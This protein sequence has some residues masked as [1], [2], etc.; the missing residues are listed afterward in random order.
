VAFY[1]SP[2]FPERIAR[3]AEGGPEFLTDIAEM[4]SGY[5]SRNIAWNEPRH[6]YVVTLLNRP[7]SEFDELKAFFI[8]VR[9]MGHGFRF[10]DVADFSATSTVGLLGTGVGTGSAT[11]QM[12][13]RYTS[14]SNNFDRAIK[15]PVSGT[16]LIYKNAVAQTI[17]PSAPGAG[18]VSVDTTTGIVTFGGTAPGG[19]DVLTWSGQ[20]DVPVRFDTDWLQATQ[21]GGISKLQTWDQIVLRELRL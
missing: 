12:N 4:S 5:E 7:A 9:G 20:F 6:R 3:D 15:K 10:K 21:R 2:R 11:Y 13:K 17:V 1:E 8:A 14:G 19:G 16:L 18:Q